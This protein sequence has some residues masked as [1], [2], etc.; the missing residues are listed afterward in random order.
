MIGLIIYHINAIGT[1]LNY[2]AVE[3]FAV[4]FAKMNFALRI[5]LERG[6]HFEKNSSEKF[7]DARK[8]RF[9][10]FSALRRFIVNNCLI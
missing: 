2:S 10:H 4:K 3:L 1:L 8:F 5:F 7:Y 6:Y 9:A